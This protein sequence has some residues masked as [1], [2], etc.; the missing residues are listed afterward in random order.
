MNPDEAALLRA[1]LHVRGGKRRI[2]QKK[3]SAGIAALHDA[4][5]FAMQ[6]FFLS[7]DY[8]ELLNLRDNEIDFD[9]DYNLF[10][11]LNNRTSSIKQLR[12]RILNI[13]HR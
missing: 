2:S 10:I 8:E 6:R 9:D 13:Y 7:P 3:L 12:K 1:Q 4:F 11:I 5:I